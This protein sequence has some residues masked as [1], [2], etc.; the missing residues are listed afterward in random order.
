MTQSKQTRYK[1]T[2][3]LLALISWAGTHRI[4]AKMAQ[5]HESSISLMVSGNRAVT[6]AVADRMQEATHGK[7]KRDKLISYPL[8]DRDR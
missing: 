1:A 3:E 2:D 6:P 5:V 4:A 7:F 8:K